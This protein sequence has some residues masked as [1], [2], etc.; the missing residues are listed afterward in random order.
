[1]WEG[2][3]VAE[4]EEETV[5]AV[6]GYGGIGGDE[7]VAGEAE[8]EI[9]VGAEGEET[10]KAGGDIEDE[11][12]AVGDHDVA[13]PGHA[14]T[15][16]EAAGTGIGMGGEEMVDAAVLLVPEGLEVGKEGVFFEGVKV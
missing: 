13:A 7:E 2:G 3:R 14:M 8:G 4:E 11:E 9:G 16:R 10:E 5:E 1:M 6:E 12:E 15:E